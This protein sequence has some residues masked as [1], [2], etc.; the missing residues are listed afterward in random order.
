MTSMSVREKIVKSF[1]AIKWALA[2][3]NDFSLAFHWRIRDAIRKQ[4]ERKNQKANKEIIRILE[5]LRMSWIN[6]WFQLDRLWLQ[7]FGVWYETNDDWLYY[8]YYY[9]RYHGWSLTLS[10]CWFA[11]VCVRRAMTFNSFLHCVGHL[12]RKPN[13][14]REFNSESCSR[15]FYTCN[16]FVVD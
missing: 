13:N 4:K 10:S 14:T 16:S 9:S 12:R 15:F 2:V 8:Y 7:Y 3:W 11:T 5:C 6:M 1:Y